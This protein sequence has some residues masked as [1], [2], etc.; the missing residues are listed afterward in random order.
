MNELV[1]SDT[2]CLRHFIC[3]CIKCG[4]VFLD[5]FSCSKAGRIRKPCEVA[6][7]ARENEKEVSLDELLFNKFLFARARAYDKIWHQKCLAY[8]FSKGDSPWKKRV[9]LSRKRA[10]RVLRTPCS[11][12]ATN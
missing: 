7:L 2:F 11:N 5:K 10:R 9:T 8:Q 4:T 6:K 3:C 1:F 12:N